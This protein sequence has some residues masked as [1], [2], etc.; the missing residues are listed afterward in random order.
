LV[1]HLTKHYV[2]SHGWPQIIHRKLTKLR[3][4]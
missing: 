3:N 1:E 2:I 4:N